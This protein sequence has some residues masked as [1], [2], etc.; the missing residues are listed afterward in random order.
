MSS[1]RARK[2]TTDTSRRRNC[3][4]S[5]TTN[6]PVLSRNFAGFLTG[7]NQA[8][9]RLVPLPAFGQMRRQISQLVSERVE[10]RS[11]RFAFWVLRSNQGPPSLLAKRSGCAPACPRSNICELMGSNRVGCG[12]G[13]FV[14][15]EK[16]GEPLA[17]TPKH[18]TA[19]PP[20]RIGSPGVQNQKL[21]ISTLDFGRAGLW[22]NYGTGLVVSPRKARRMRGWKE[23]GRRVGTRAIESKVQSLRSKVEDQMSAIMTLDFARG[24]WTDDGTGHVALPEKARENHPRPTRL[25]SSQVGSLPSETD[26]R[27]GS[28]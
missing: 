5:S 18:P 23:V 17:R 14:S 20:R 16:P 27:R 2:W 8:W 4:T 3:A 24:L 9:P 28:V 10:T 15:T 21:A 19:D 7:H 26:G 25:S 12:T 13:H 11:W 22:T 1:A 6:S